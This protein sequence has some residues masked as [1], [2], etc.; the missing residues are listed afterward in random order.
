M[1][2]C[3]LVANTVACQFENPKVR[4]PIFGSSR[5]LCGTCAEFLRAS[6]SAFG[7]NIDTLARIVPYEHR[8]Y[9]AFCMPHGPT[10][11]VVE[12][13]AVELEGALENALSEPVQDS[14]HALAKS[15]GGHLLPSPDP[16]PSPSPF[17]YYLS[18][19]DCDTV[20]DAS[21]GVSDWQPS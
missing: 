12:E 19:S 15:V 9:S 11:D 7:A 13:V 16:R 4:L 5:P 10:A 6:F 20:S 8:A 14:F 17:D 2:I 1:P 3:A 18:L 21:E